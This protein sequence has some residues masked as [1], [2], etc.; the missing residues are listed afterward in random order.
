MSIGRLRCVVINVTDLQVAYAFW[1]A[2]TGLEVIGPRNGWHGWLGYLGTRHPW[3]HEV[4]LQRVDTSPVEAGTPSRM[5]TNAVHLDITPNDG[6]DRAI[7]QIIE[8]GGTLK[9]P[10]SIYPRPGSHGDEAP[11]ID[12]AVM[13]DPFGNEFCLVQPLTEAQ[14]Q[15]A[16]AA[17]ASTDQE[18]RASAGLTSGAPPTR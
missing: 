14:V 2:V 12:W 10:P 3:K 9:K 4:I 1:S 11:V 8:L 16:V 18:W 5:T 6:I 17:P 7:E 15:A 13:Q